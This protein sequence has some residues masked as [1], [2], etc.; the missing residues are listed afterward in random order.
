MILHLFCPFLLSVV[1]GRGRGK[2]CWGVS[3]L[4][5]EPWKSRMWS[6]AVF[7]FWTGWKKKRKRKARRRWR[8]IFGGGCL[9]L[10]LPSDVPSEETACQGLNSSGFGNVAFS[11]MFVWSPSKYEWQDPH[12]RLDEGRRSG[13]DSLRECLNESLDRHEESRKKVKI[14]S[15]ICHCFLFCP[16][17]LSLNGVFL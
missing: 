11:I 17:F 8:K 14:V 2:K 13:L 3:S 6:F 16:F 5:L 7:C 1:K 15:L 4:C 9:F 12:P 10:S